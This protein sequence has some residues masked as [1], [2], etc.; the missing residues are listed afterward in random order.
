MGH[1][2]LVKIM[3]QG[4]LAVIAKASPDEAVLVVKALY[5]SGIRVGEITMRAQGA[6]AVLEKVVNEFG[7]K[8]T[9]GAGDVRNADAAHA[10]IKAG[11]EYTPTEVVTAWESHADAVMIFPCVAVGGSKYLASLKHAFS[12][13]E[14]MPTGSLDL[15]TTREFLGAGAC[16][17][18]VGSAFI[19]ARTISQGSYVV[20]EDR[21]RRYLDEVAKA[22]AKPS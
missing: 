1:E 14:M 7:D 22:R 12:E 21:G 16:A 11:A 5:A 15:G 6:L 3:E 18:S 13:I 4:V 9:F 2:T 20:F 19:D 17:V 8:V 10:C